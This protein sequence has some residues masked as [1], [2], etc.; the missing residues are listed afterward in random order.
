MYIGVCILTFHVQ[1]SYIFNPL[2][3]NAVIMLYLSKSMADYAAAKPLKTEP[4]KDWYYSSGTANI[5]A[6]VIRDTTGGNLAD[7]TNF[8]RT[9]LFDRIGMY[10]AIIEPDA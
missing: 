9:R 3:K 7:V 10:S 2:K 5:I 8:A 6:R 1:N 4:D